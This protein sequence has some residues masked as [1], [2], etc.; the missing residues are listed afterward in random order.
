MDNKLTS[1]FSAGYFSFSSSFILLII[2]SEFVFNRLTRNVV[3]GGDFVNH[4]NNLR[5][6]SFCFK[7]V[8][9]NFKNQ[10]KSCVYLN[11]PFVTQLSS[12]KINNFWMFIKRTFWIKH[13]FNK[14]HKN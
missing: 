4:S 2:S 6:S 10:N 14:I 11:Y 13:I 8:R 3:T 7:K 1:T 9:L 12:N 5:S